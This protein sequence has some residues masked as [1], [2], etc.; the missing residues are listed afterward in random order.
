MFEWPKFQLQASARA[1][2][3]CADDSELREVLADGCPPN[4]TDWCGRPLPGNVLINPLQSILEFIRVLEARKAHASNVGDHLYS[5]YAAELLFY[6][7]SLPAEAEAF[8]VNIATKNGAYEFIVY[9]EGQNLFCA[10]VDL[11]EGR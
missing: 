2:G 5:K 7:K 10:R 1:V 4:Q 8:A 6:L 11:L 9:P 3:F